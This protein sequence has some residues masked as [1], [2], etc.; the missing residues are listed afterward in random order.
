MTW[1]FHWLTPEKG[2]HQFRYILVIDSFCCL[3]MHVLLKRDPML[4]PLHIGV[5]FGSNFMN[6]NKNEKMH[7]Q[8]TIEFGIHIVGKMYLNWC[9]SFYGVSQWFECL[10]WISQTTFYT[11]WHDKNQCSP[12]WTFIFKHYPNT[13]IND[14]R[15]GNCVELLPEELYPMA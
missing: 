9:T 12:S 4:T 8:T 1:S 10:S 14:R 6:F 5:H 2:V 3:L 13:K 11:S 7:K 15:M